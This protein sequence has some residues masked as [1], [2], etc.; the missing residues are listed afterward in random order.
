MKARE[1][2][3]GIVE[4]PSERRVS[5][6]FAQRARHSAC[7]ALQ[8]SRLTQSLGLRD[9]GGGWVW[10]GPLCSEAGI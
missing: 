8:A 5:E 3:W 10:V 9:Q 1:K 2:S 6:Q 7:N 4:P